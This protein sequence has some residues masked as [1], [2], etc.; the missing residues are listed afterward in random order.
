MSSLPEP[1]DTQTPQPQAEP[2]TPQNNIAG[3]QKR[4][5]AAM[6]DGFLAMAVSFP[7]FDHFG[8]WES[9]KNNTEVP[10][11]I[12]NGLALFSLSLFFVMHG[13]LLY[14]YGQTIGKRI[15][16]LAIVTLDDHKPAFSQLILNRYLPQWVVGFVPGVGPLLAVLDV[17]Y[18][19]FND[20]NCAV[21]DLLAKTKVIDLSVARVAKSNSLFA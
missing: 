2:P 14:H 21:H 7:V 20:Q 15:M 16:G 3:R 1:N 4:F 19:L 17:A 11:S 18:I 13:Y 12:S 8:V 5:A 10:Q 9:L 6:I